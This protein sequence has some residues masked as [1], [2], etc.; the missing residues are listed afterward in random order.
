MLPNLS[1]EASIA[2]ISKPNKDTTKKK[3]RKKITN[4]FYKHKQKYSQ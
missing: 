1:Y 4:Q 3:K 2:L